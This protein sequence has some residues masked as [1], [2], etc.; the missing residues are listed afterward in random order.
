MNLRKLKKAV[1]AGVE[2]SRDRKSRTVA[3]SAGGLSYRLGEAAFSDE[4]EMAEHLRSKL[5]VMAVM[6]GR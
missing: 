2:L 3:A 4:R 6:P 1:G 5:P